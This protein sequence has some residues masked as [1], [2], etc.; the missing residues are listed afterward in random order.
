MKKHVN[1]L[2]VGDVFRFDGDDY[3]VISYEEVTDK[4]LYLNVTKSKVFEDVAMFGVVEV[5]D[6]SKRTVTNI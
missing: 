2:K 6:I 3:I 5:V 1:E 4:P